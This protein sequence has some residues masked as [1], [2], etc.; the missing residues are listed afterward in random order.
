MGSNTIV[1]PNIGLPNSTW[2]LIGWY[3]V[4]QRWVIRCWVIQWYTVSYMGDYSHYYISLI[5]KFEQLWITHLV[6]I[7]IHLLVVVFQ[8]CFTYEN[9]C[10]SG[11]NPDLVT[12]WL[13]MSL[14][15]APLLIF[16]DPLYPT[17]L[18]PSRIGYWR[19]L[20]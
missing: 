12:K 9:I 1:L 18:F 7:T 19:Y 15:P 10:C 14:F 8:S 4:T 13:T 16:I 17:F 3:W 11:R 2:E 6:V 5:F 20:K